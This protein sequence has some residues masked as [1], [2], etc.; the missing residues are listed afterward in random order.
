MICSM[1]LWQ[2]LV[3][4]IIHLVTNTVDNTSYVIF[5]FTLVVAVNSV[6]TVIFLEIIKSLVLFR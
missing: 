3:S 2:I 1:G 5:S 6:V 4:G